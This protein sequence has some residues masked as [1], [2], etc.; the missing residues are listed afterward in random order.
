MIHTVRQGET[1][2]VIAANY[3]IP[4]N[5]LLIANQISNPNLVYI[6][7]KIV[8]PNLPD[9]ETI[10]YSIHISVSNKRLTLYLNGQVVKEYPIAVGR[11]VTATPIGD[12]V[13]VNRQPNPGGPFGAMWL[14]LSK[15]HYG[16][17]GTN[18]PSSI[19]KA[20]SHGCIRMFNKDV[21]ELSSLVPNGTKVLIRP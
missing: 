6:G 21:L 14:S 10:P 20:V 17:H 19:G 5:Q 13:I 11:M 1:L 3:R 16:I 8:I 18:D 12:F 2:S 9:P 4:L 15:L 7:Q